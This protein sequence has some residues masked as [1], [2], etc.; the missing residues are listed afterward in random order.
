M[1]VLNKEIC[2]KYDI[3]IQ[4]NIFNNDTLIVG[5][6]EKEEIARFL[7]A[8][9]YVDKI[10]LE[11]LHNYDFTQILKEIFQSQLKII[12]ID[13][14]Y[15]KRVVRNSIAEGIS[16]EDSKKNVDLKDKLKKSV[17]ADRIKEIADFIIDNN[18]TYN[19]LMQQ[20]DQIV[21]EKRRYTG[22]VICPEQMNIPIE[23]QNSLYEFIKSMKDE[24]GEKLK[25]LLVTGSCARGC[26]HKGYSDIDIIMVVNRN[27]ANV[28]NAINR[29]I[30]KSKIKIGTTVYS[31]KE[32]S[33]Q[34][35]DEKTI[36]AIYEMLIGNYRPTV[37]DSDLEIPY[38]SLADVKQVLSNSLPG[39]LHNLRR[40][41]YDRTNTDYDSVFKDLSHI[42][43][44]IL[45]QEGIDAS[46]YEDIY[47]KF[48]EKYQSN[49]FNVKSFIEGNN[50]EDIFD[51]AIDVIDNK[52]NLEKEEN[53]MRE[54]ARGLLV[55]NNGLLLIHRIKQKDGIKQ[56]YYVIPGGGR[57]EGESYE[58]TVKREL[59]EELGIDVEPVR[60]LYKQKIN[61]EIHNYFL[62]EYLSGD[63][64][65]GEGPEFNSEEY[66][67]RGQ[68]IPEIIPL[69]ELYK[70]NL[71]EPLKTNLQI[72]LI[73]YGSIKDIKYRDISL[74]NSEQGIEK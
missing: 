56:E 29:N 38:T 48:A 49:I 35:V 61:N 13:T 68:Y 1:I 5:L 62:C 18:G 21:K 34:Q 67:T 7:K 65:T 16:L 24:L 15:K 58:D 28:R 23:Y 17:A 44:I 70:I 42:L 36:Y 63:I 14:D 52:M 20:V 22:E 27:D 8:H 26:V 40:K 4:N 50:K 37:I 54:T 43:R 72:D 11:S 9:Y 25:L 74:T 46:S 41:L 33:C 3:D 69:Q 53:V 2:Q 71:Q 55:I 12:Y 66:S 47:K 51:Y 30:K 39:Q 57:E 59:K 73:K 60:L 31:E 10:S 19:Q 6:L 32:F 64:G 45:M